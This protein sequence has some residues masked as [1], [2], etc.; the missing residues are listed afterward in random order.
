MRYKNMLNNCYT[1]IYD[2][3]ELFLLSLMMNWC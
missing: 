3:G 2:L 1:L